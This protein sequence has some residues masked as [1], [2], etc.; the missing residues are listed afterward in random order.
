[1]VPLSADSCR[2]IDK[3]LPWQATLSYSSFRLTGYRLSVED[4]FCRPCVFSAI[5]SL[6]RNDN[7]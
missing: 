6:K 2:P 7:P 4:S 1:M 3:G 5:R